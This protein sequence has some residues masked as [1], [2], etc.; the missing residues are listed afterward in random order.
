M[1][2][3]LGSSVSLP[4]PLSHLCINLN[5]PDCAQKFILIF[6]VPLVLQCDESVGRDLLS[7]ANDSQ[8]FWGEK[9]I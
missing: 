1:W 3:S 4:F 6:S 7:R 8:N 2:P 9:E 5:F